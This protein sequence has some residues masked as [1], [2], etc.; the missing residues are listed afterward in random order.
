M[1]QFNESVR[2]GNRFEGGLKFRVKESLE[3]GA[4]YQRSI[5]FPKHMFWYWAGSSIIEEIGQGLIDGFISHV[6][7]ASWRYSC[8]LFSLKNALSYGATN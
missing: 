3:I 4:G 5:I 8:C 1:D 2:F 7:K 6:T